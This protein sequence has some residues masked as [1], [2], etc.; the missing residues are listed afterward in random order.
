MVKKN[1]SDLTKTL[2]DLVHSDEAE[3]YWK[4]KEKITTTDIN[5]V[6]WDLIEVAM[7]DQPV[8]GE[9]LFQNMLVVCVG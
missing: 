4:Q 5:S 1:M 3:E 9:S 8:L 6:N 2:Y 7:K